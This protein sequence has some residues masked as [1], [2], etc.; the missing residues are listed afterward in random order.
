MATTEKT[1]EPDLEKKAGVPGGDVD[2]GSDTVS[3]KAGDILSAEH[4]DPVLNAKMHLVNNVSFSSTRP[5]CPRNKLP[6]RLP[7]N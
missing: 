7:K 4:T 6:F 1:L 2:S 3:V 5:V